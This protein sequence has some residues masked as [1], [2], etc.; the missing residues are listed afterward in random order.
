MYRIFYTNY[1]TQV[2]S[3]DIALLIILSGTDNELTD[4]EEEQ[5]SAFSL[6]DMFRNVNIYQQ[7]MLLMQFTNDLQSSSSNSQIRNHNIQVVSNQVTNVRVQ[8]PR[9]RSRVA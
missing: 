8:Q 7:H 9:T 5:D 1:G 2:Y 3:K 6:Q 4:I